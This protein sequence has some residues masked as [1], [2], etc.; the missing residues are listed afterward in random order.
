MELNA[1]DAAAAAADAVTDAVTDAT[2]LLAHDVN[3]TMQ[4][5]LNPE[6]L[7]L[8]RFWVQRASWI[9]WHWFNLEGKRVAHFNGVCLSPLM[10]NKGGWVTEQSYPISPITQSSGAYSAPNC[11]WELALTESGSSALLLSTNEEPRANWLHRRPPIDDWINR[12]HLRSDSSSPL[13]G[14]NRTLNKR[15]KRENN[16]QSMGKKKKKKILSA[17]RAPTHPPIHPST[18]PPIHH[19]IM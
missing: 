16:N 6:F 13:S 11:R 7:N 5:P 15:Q 17:I 1:T 2:L 10:I 12:L 3:Q 8:S 19:A 18:H 9:I 4:T 14:I